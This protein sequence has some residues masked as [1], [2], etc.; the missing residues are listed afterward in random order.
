MTLPKKTGSFSWSRSL[1]D[2]EPY[3]LR[4]TIE[5]SGGVKES[6]L[7]FFLTN[8][9]S[10]ARACLKANVP[11]GMT[12]EL[13]LSDLH[14]AWREPRTFDLDQRQEA[15][16]AVLMHAY[17]IRLLFIEFDAYLL[18]EKGALPL[19]VF[20]PGRDAKELAEQVAFEV[21]QF[22]LA[23]IRGD[24]IELADLE[25]MMRV[26]EIE[27]KNAMRKLIQSAKGG[28]QRIFDRKQKHCQDILLTFSKSRTNPY[29]AAE[30]P[31]V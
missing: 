23:A 24:F 31:R 18:W 12:P 7:E 8:L 1:L 11:D 13:K 28:K 20:K 5:T 10:D 26:N 25:T 27:R 29:Q 22:T 15:A 6:G 3:D 2:F 4:E 19:G 14:W 30:K 21:L 17:G 9:E 16:V